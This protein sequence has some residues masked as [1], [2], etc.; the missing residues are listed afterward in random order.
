MG[1][2]EVFIDQVV[3]YMISFGPLGGFVLAMI[4]AFLPI[5]PLGLIVG[6]NILSFGSVFGFLLSY[7]ATITGCMLVFWF[8]RYYIK[9]RYMNW[10]SEKNQIKIKK[11]MKKISHMKLTTLAVVIALP[12]TPSFFV[13]VA[14]GLSDVSAKKYMTALLVGKPAMLLFYGYV[15]VSLVDSLKD[16]RNLI[17]VVILVTIT[18][19]ISKVIEKVVKVED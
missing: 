16:P 18:Y 5:L 10:F 3:N 7:I 6:L 13:N 2:I 12:I 19:V 4:E 9:D 1:N 15:A 8:I 14:G 11:L 17:R